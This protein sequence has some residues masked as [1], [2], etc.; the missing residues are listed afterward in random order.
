MLKKI[1]C[2]L[3][4][5]CSPRFIPAERHSDHS[6]EAVAVQAKTATAELAQDALLHPC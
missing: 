5:T 3:K 6:P 1:Q 2:P 4:L